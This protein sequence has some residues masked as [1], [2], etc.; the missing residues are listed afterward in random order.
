MR[1]SATKTSALSTLPAAPGSLSHSTT[2]SVDLHAK[3]L[4]TDGRGGFACGSVS[5][6]RSH[7][8]QG[9]VVTGSYRAKQCHILLKSLEV[10]VLSREH[11]YPLVSHRFTP[12]LIRPNAREQIRSFTHRPWPQWKYVLGDGFVVEHEFFMRHGNPSAVFT[13]KLLPGAPGF[14][15]RVRPLLS[16]LPASELLAR[17][18]KFPLSL[19][20]IGP[21]RHLWRPESGAPAL[22]FHT[23]ATFEPDPRWYEG[24]HYQGDLEDGAP[25]TE[26]LGSPG[27]FTWDLSSGRAD[28]IVEVGDHRERDEIESFDSRQRVNRLRGAERTRRRLIGDPNVLAAD[29][30]LVEDPG[31]DVRIASGYPSSS[32]RPTEPLIAFRGL[33][34]ATDRLNLAHRVLRSLVGEAP[35]VARREK[36]K[37][38]E[39]GHQAPDAALWLVVAIREFFTAVARSRYPL[40]AAGRDE[41]L[42]AISG[43]IARFQAGDMHRVELSEEGLLG[44][45]SSPR[46]EENPGAHL[47][48]VATQALWL[49]ALWI[50]AEED[51]ELEGLFERANASFTDLFWNEEGGYLADRAAPAASSQP[52]PAPAARQILAIG[53]LPRVLLQEPRASLV[54]ELVEDQLWTPHG[55][56]VSTAAGP[57]DPGALESWLLG[58]FIE[59][60]L[61][62]HRDEHNPA[63]KATERFIVPWRSLLVQDGLGHLGEP[64]GAP[65]AAPLA[66]SAAATGELLRVLKILAQIRDQAGT[67]GD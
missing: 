16:G 51:H 62:V 52:P 2:T 37:C 3:W 1:S 9:F 47:F 67:A 20:R 13:W 27:V 18:A 19:E 14:L 42:D 33:C 25:V 8:S 15:L 60:W 28:L 12:G 35:R 63:Q 49:N 34:L 23:G 64:G 6:I 59:A 53:G 36:S 45:A 5:G 39:G 29:H 38:H 56:R 43:T 7:R 24:F 31:G 61:R 54:L 10:T 21:H 50:G 66:F 46:A 44:H 22:S 4:E 17:H 32:T 65:G 48:N 57:G 41:L 40:E 58:P 30:Y 11:E 55:L 26:D